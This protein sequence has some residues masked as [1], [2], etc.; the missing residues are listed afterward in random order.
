MY[1]YVIIYHTVR[2]SY[3]ESFP[4]VSYMYIYSY[5]HIYIYTYMYE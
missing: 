4:Y 1:Y 5:V 2:I 3:M